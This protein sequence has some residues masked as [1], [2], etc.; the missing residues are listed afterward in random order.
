MPNSKNSNLAIWSPLLINSI[1][2]L[3]AFLGGP[4]L[5]VWIWVLIVLVYWACMALLIWLDN[6]TDSITHWLAPSKGRWFWNGLALL[7]VLPLLPTFLGNYH[8]FSEW[9]I[10]SLGL[11]LAAVNPWLEEGYWRGLLLDATKSWPGWVSLLYSSSLFAIAHLSLGVHSVAS[12]HPIAIIAIGVMGLVWGIVY[13]K[14]GSLRWVIFGHVLVDLFNL[15]VPA[16]LN[17]Y[18]PP[19]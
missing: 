8:L 5:G 4:V 17:L 11:I 6:G 18:L 7:L 15:T 12:R 13:K 3:I 16:L 2:F 19:V 14:T 1:L 9:W 10:L